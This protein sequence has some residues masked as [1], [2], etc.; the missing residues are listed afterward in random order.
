MH[1][2]MLGT[3]TDDRGE[4]YTPVPAASLARH[5]ESSQS[6]L[7]ARTLQR[8]LK[9]VVKE[10]T[11]RWSV[12]R[13]AINVAMVI[14]IVV[15]LFAAIILFGRF[16]NGLGV[17]VLIVLV[18]AGVIGVDRSISR[19]LM[20]R[21][22]G[23]TIVAHGF[24]A[25]C[26]YSLQGLD[27]EPDGAAVCPECGAAWRLSRVT[28]PHWGSQLLPLAPS[29]GLALRVRFRRPPVV[30]DDRGMLCRR[31]DAGLAALRRDRRAALGIDL[32][33]ELREAIRGPTRWVRLTVVGLI[34]I[35]GTL[36]IASWPSDPRMDPADIS[37][38]RVLWVL[39]MGFLFVLLVQVF[40]T[41]FGVTRGRVVTECVGRGL[42]ASCAG[43]LAEIA[44]RGFRVCPDCGAS[45]A[46]AQ[47]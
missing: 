24:C 22:L 36:L 27:T 1:S 15:L 14:L 5:A 47:G 11:K 44:E 43:R 45:W 2:L 16:V 29:P 23:A 30:S 7:A 13:M 4:A 8:T 41:E 32:C 42:C 33:R 19:K 12:E 31:L 28:R 40:A 39:G 46:A 34:V 17:L 25:R 20:Q 18:I 10:E 37:G 6:Q 38:L 21:G 26:G 9:R 3:A 35:A